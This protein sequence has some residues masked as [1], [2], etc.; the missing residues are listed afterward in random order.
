MTVPEGATDL[1]DLS[2]VVDDRGLTVP[3]EAVGAGS[4]S[5]APDRDAVDPEDLDVTD[6]ARELLR[7]LREAGDSPV[8]VADA[9][10]HVD[11]SR[12]SVRNY[13]G[14][15]ADEGALRREETPGTSADLFHLD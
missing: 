5:G 6:G 15:L 8:T 3:A 9:V 11:V 12:R 1:S 10:E 7:A 14:A 13:L 2:L 4:G